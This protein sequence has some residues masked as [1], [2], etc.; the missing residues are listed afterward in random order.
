[1]EGLKQQTLQSG[2]K[3][4]TLHSEGGT[5]VEN[6]QELLK[7]AGSIGVLMPGDAI[8]SVPLPSQ[9]CAETALKRRLEDCADSGEGL[10]QP[11]L[12]SGVK[13]PTLPSDG[14]CEGLK[15]PMLQSGEVVTGL[16]KE[17]HTLENKRKRK[18]T[19]AK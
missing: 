9:A 5:V 14:G 11:T 1:M 6:S 18:Q 19:H 10:K 2:V 7:A 12:Q 13:K 8:C 17:K 15:Q 4:P 3:Q 16:K